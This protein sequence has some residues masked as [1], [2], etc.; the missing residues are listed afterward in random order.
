MGWSTREVAQLAGTTLRAVRH[1]HEIG[2]LEVPE[3]MPNGYKSY[4]TRHLVRL[5]EIR[6]LTRLGLPLATISRATQVG[7]DL[8][9]TLGEVEAEL[10]TRIAQLQQAKKEVSKLRRHP[11]ETDLPFDV[12]VAAKEAQ[13]SP[14]DR[15]LYAVITQMGSER[16][17]SHWSDILRGSVGVPGSD[18]FDALPEEADEPTRQRL[19]DLMAPQVI[20]LLDQHPLPAE[21][22]PSKPREQSTYARTVIDAM[23]DL[24]NTAQLDVIARIWR[25]AG[26]V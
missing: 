21:A 1:Y 13:L 5:L 20:A 4:D 6:R 14:A 10:E 23:V 19:A 8:D 12:S 26:I 9:K 11:I 2:L 7:A 15:S 25:A 16:G 17:S 3:R 24:Y 22:L 18:E